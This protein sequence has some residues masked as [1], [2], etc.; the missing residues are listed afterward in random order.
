MS[1]YKAEDFIV[2]IETGR[3]DKISTDALEM[4]AERFRELEKEV[5][6]KETIVETCPTET[7]NGR[8]IGKFK[9]WE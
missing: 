6:P 7:Q 2:F 1:E 9:F 4:I 8:W 3:M 5:K